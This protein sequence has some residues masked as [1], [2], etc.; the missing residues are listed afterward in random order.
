MTIEIAIDPATDDAT[1]WYER[2]G[3][4]SSVRISW[5]EAYFRWGLKRR[6]DRREF[7]G[8]GSSLISL[9]SSQSKPMC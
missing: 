6:F 3:R 4:R 9:R 2:G 1:I 8:G 5:N 7:E